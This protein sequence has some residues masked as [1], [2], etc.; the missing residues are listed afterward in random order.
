M[1]NAHTL[2]VLAVVAVVGCDSPQDKAKDAEEARRAA[3]QQVAQVTQTTER[4]ELEIQQKADDDVGRLD[5]E[6]AKR[7]GEADL[8]ADRK[9]ND[10]TEA[11]WRARE[12][13]HADS[14]NK[15]DGLDHDV[16]ELQAQLEKKLS[17]AAAATVVHELQA[18]AAALRRSIHDL[19]HCDADDLESVKRSIH[20]GFDD[21][22][23]ALADAKNRV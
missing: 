13:A 19:E 7:I 2:F 16:A 17:P 22:E 11:L 6:S 15:L 9:A 1:S 3:D 4:K 10:A 14:S 5:R 21:L 20:T 18:K 23:Q 8:G 12:Q